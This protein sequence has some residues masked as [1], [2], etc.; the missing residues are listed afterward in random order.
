MRQRAAMRKI[1]HRFTAH[2]RKLTFDQ[3]EEIRRQHAK[4]DEPATLASRFGINHNTVRGILEGRTYVY[5]S[6]HERVQIEEH[7]QRAPKPAPAND[8]RLVCRMERA[9]RA[10]HPS[11]VMSE[12]QKDFAALLAREVEMRKGGRPRKDGGKAYQL[13]T[14][15]PGKP[16]LMVQRAPAVDLIDSLPP[17]YG[18][19]SA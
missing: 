15:K 9:K 6:R 13:V 16:Q 12:A 14:G 8:P 5:P 11:S 10:G 18:S 3:A 17:F 19:Q 1:A 4:G 2:N 7:N